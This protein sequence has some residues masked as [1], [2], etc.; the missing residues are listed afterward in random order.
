[1]LRV[2]ALASLSGLTIR[3]CR[4]LW[5]RSQMWLRSRVP[6]AVAAAPIR[7]LAWESPYAMGRALEETKGKK[8]KKK[9]NSTYN[10]T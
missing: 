4:E 8:K 3:R 1:M 10:S 2:R 5:C 7:P 6:V 9:L